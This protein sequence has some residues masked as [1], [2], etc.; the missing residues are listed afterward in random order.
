MSGWRGELGAAIRQARVGAGRSQAELAEV[1]GVRQSSVS[2]WERGSTAPAARHVLG[3]LGVLGMRLVRLLI[4]DDDQRRP[5][6][7][8]GFVGGGNSG[9]DG[10]VPGGERPAQRASG[11]AARTLRPGTGPLSDGLRW[12]RGSGPDGDGPVLVDYRPGE[13]FLW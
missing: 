7:S 6:A 1:L 8:R 13:P 10:P 4:A 3:L 2:Q 9:E 12:G 5:V 11:R